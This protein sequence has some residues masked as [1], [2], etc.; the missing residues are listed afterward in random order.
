MKSLLPKLYAYILLHTIPKQ[1]IQNKIV[2][3]VYIYSDLKFR[4]KM[5]S[6]NADSS[7]ITNTIY[8]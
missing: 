4:Y 6:S 3:F 5:Q 7:I 1:Q 2:L 8:M